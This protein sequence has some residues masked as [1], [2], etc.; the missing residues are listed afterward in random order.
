LTPGRISALEAQ[1]ASLLEVLD[2][3][4]HLREILA[5]DELQLPNWYVGSGFIAQ[6][7]WNH[8]HGFDLLAAR[9]LP[10]AMLIAVDLITKGLAAAFLPEGAPV[11]LGPCP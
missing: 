7:Y 9:G 3:N 8:R 11:N 10:R 4:A 6:T 2:H 5:S 1:A